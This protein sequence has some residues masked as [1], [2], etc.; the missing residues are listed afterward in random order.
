MMQNTEGGR[1]K[2]DGSVRLRGILRKIARYNR[3]KTSA[4]CHL[5]SVT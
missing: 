5:S 3:D 4:I 2:A 1:Q